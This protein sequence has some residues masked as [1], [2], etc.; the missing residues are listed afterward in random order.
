MMR[1]TLLAATYLS[2]CSYVTSNA[3]VDGESGF[4]WTGTCVVLF[5]TNI[6]SF[7]IENSRKTALGCLMNQKNLLKTEPLFPPFTRLCIHF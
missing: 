3:N 6:V 1:T 4:E 7:K 5:F 2:S